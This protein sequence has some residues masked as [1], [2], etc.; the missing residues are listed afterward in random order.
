M[1]NNGVMTKQ[2]LKK[3]F[4]EIQEDKDIYY[5]A[6]LTMC[7]FSKKK[8]YRNVSELAVILN[9]ES[10]L[11]L[12]KV[13]G[14]ETITIP[15]QDEILSYVQSIY[16]VYYKE[17][18][19]KTDSAIVNLLGLKSKAELKQLPIRQVKYAIDELFNGGITKDD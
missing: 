3:W 11:N 5:M 19:G 8:K 12:I 6:L 1:K 14:G 9:K 17:L 16:Y 10:F 13:Y 7:L 4:S 2:K 18:E 15:T